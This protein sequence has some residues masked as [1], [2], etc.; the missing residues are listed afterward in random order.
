MPTVVRA[1]NQLS[2]G[3]TRAYRSGIYRCRRMIRHQV[4]RVGRV[5]TAVASD[6]EVVLTFDD[7]PDPRFTGPLLA[8]LAELD[9]RAT[10]FC[11]GSCASAHPGLVRSMV[12]A[13]HSVGSH[14]LTHT[15]PWTLGTISLVR[16]IRNGHRAVEKAMGR[17]SDLFR[18]PKGHLDMRVASAARI[19]GLRSW[20]W[21]VD[22]ADWRPG[23]TSAEIDVGCASAGGG[24]VVLL[25][26]GIVDGPDAGRMDR[27]ATLA[28]V[29][30]V[31]E[32]IR[33][34]GLGF[35]VLPM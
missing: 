33:S 3:A 20:L 23:A 15:D 24:D 5:S 31:V 11:I 28:A 29:P 16:E 2:D 22:P 14:S 19:A 34:R 27:A 7:G 13:G 12:D 35:A 8:I 10:F 26:D 21:T 4:P 17:S 6:N 9:V 25:H 30:I 32:R 18:P 1:G